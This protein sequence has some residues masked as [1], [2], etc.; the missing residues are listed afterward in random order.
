L[1]GWGLHEDRGSMSSNLKVLFVEKLLL[2]GGGFPR[3]VH[4][5]KAN[6]FSTGTSAG[7][8]ENISGARQKRRGCGAKW[9]QIF[10]SWRRGGRKEE[11]WEKMRFAPGIRRVELF[12][13]RGC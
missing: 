5:K 9:R 4:R 3:H 8:P 10:G 1:A 7:C 2:G 13:G 11:G 12:R 6:R